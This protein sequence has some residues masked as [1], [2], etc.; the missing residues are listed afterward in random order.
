MLHCFSAITGAQRLRL[1]LAVLVVAGYFP[2][3]WISLCPMITLFVILL[4]T[5]PSLSLPWV[6]HRQRQQHRT[7][8]AALDVGMVQLAHDG[9]VCWPIR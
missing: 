4:A 6:L 9:R 8:L 5:L 7:L 3:S 2:A 1:A